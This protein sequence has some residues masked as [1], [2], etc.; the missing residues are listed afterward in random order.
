M[1]LLCFALSPAAIDLHPIPNAEAG[2]ATENGEKNLCSSQSELS[3]L[4]Y[5]IDFS[6]PMQ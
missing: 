3:G 4:A 2:K 1:T 5:Y 6:W